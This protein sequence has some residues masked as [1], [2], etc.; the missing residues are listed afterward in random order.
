MIVHI[1]L[2]ADVASSNAR[3]FCAST[4]TPHEC[5]SFSD[6]SRSCALRP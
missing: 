2:P 6:A 5:R 3:P 4:L 1:S